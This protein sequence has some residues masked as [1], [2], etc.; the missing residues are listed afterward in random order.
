MWGARGVLGGR[1]KGWSEGHTRLALLLLF[2]LLLHNKSVLDLLKVHLRA[3]PHRLED[4]RLFFSN[5]LADQDSAILSKRILLHF[6]LHEH[7]VV[8][9]AVHSDVQQLSHGCHALLLLFGVRNVQHHIHFPNLQL[10]VF[11]IDLHVHIVV[12]EILRLQIPQPLHRPRGRFG[13]VCTHNHPLIQ[14]LAP[15]DRHD[16]HRLNLDGGVRGGHVPAEA[17]DDGE[18]VQPRVCQH[19]LFAFS[20]RLL[21]FGLA[22]PGLWD[23]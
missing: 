5:E 4:P 21:W 1:G 2:L 17:Q 19:V 18:G 3:L 14:R 12:P 13:I 8:F 20:K 9:A 16:N 6:I 10:H 11:E 22:L 23:G 7:A 15:I